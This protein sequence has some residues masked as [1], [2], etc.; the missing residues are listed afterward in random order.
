MAEPT[1]SRKIARADGRSCDFA[2][3]LS[4]AA[5]T[6]VRRPN[7]WNVCSLLHTSCVGPLY[8]EDDDAARTDTESLGP[9]CVLQARAKAQTAMSHEL[10]AVTLDGKSR[11]QTHTQGGIGA[12]RLGDDALQR[13][14]M[15]ARQRSRTRI[16]KDRRELQF[17]GV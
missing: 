1:T 10:W 11:N 13:R 15:G 7:D 9:M 3:I 2:A 16:R 8:D 14:P 6:N 12:R 5:R 17:W 4:A